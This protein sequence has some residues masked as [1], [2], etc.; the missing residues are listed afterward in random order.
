MIFPEKII[1]IKP[2]DRVLEIGPGGTPH[3]RSDV[4]L[5]KTFEDEKIAEAQRGFTPELKTIKQ[6]VYYDGGAFPFQDNEF[7]YIIVSHV[8]EHVSEIEMFLGE[9]FRVANK[10]YIEYPLIYYD[11]IY[12][13][14]EH[15]TFLKFNK[16][17]LFYLPKSMTSLS[18]FSGVTS[19]FYES[20]KAGHNCLIFSLRQ[21]L[22]EGFEWDKPFKI[23]RAKQ[24]S[25]VCWEN[26][27]I[28]PPQSRRFTIV[29]KAKA[30][31]KRILPC[32]T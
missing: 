20:L 9:I 6:I 8:L 12:D 16:C 7:D 18:E 28:N 1:G 14:P 3:P 21:E 31:L 29:R 24:I 26:I 2:N 30:I 10:G 17:K 5:E 25:D 19:C 22:F 27:K 32:S 11:Y 23:E 13:F 15:I 4:F